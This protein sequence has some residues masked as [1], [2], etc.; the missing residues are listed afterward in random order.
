MYISHVHPDL[1]LSLGNDI[2]Q[3]AQELG[4]LGRYFNNL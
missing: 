4:V 3:T 1:F 2:V